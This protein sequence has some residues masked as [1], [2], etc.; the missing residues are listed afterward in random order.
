MGMSHLKVTQLISQFINCLWN[1][2]AHT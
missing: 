2:N 1:F